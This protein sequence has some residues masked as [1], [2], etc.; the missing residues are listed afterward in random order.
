[1]QRVGFGGLG[2][3]SFTTESTESTESTED[4]EV[5]RKGWFKNY[6]FGFLCALCVLCGECF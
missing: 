5:K 6:F 4:T 2:E 1:M 3:K